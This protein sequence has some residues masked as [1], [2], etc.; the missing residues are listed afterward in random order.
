MFC[1][2]WDEATGIKASGVV[3]SKFGASSKE[4]VEF[5]PVNKFVEL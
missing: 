4:G 5:D 3:D 2:S 1:C